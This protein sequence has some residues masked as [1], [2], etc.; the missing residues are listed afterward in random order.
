MKKVPVTIAILYMLLIQTITS[1]AQN[2]IADVVNV[3]EKENSS[4]EKSTKR[5][6]SVFH[7]GEIVIT[8]KRIAN[9]EKATTNTEITGDDIEMRSDKSLAD[10]LQVVPGVQVEQTAKGFTGLAMR[11]LNHQY[12]AILIDGVPVIDPYYGGNNIDISTIPVAHVERI[13]VNR[14]VSSALYG[15]LGSAGSINI[16]TKKPDQL[17]AKAKAEYGEYNNY[18]ISA[19]AGISIGNFYTCITA[20]RQRSEGY[21]I[22]KKLTKDKRREWFDKIVTYDLADQSGSVVHPAF[23]NIDLDAVYNYLHD[24]GKWNHTEYTK[25]TVGGKIGYLLNTNTEIGISANYYHNKQ[26]SNS[27]GNNSLP[28]FDEENGEWSLPVYPR[29]YTDASGRS[30][31]DIFS[32]RAF[33]WPEDYRLAVSPYFSMEYGDLKLRINTFYIKQ[34]NN[35]EGYFNQNHDIAQMYPNST[36]YNG[37][38]QSIF[39]ETAYGVYILPQ[40]ALSK[41]N[42]LYFSL[43]YRKE[44][45]NKYEKAL[46]DTSVLAGNLGTDEYQVQDIGADYVTIAVEDQWDINTGGGMLF[47]S[48]GIS[49]DAQKLSAL[50]TYDKTSDSLI[51]LPNM[52]NDSYIWGTND[53]F[54]P[55]A[56]AM[57]EAIPNLLTIRLAG[58]IKTMFPNLSQYKDIGED[59]T[60]THEYQLD[61][62]T[63][64]SSNAGFEITILDN[65]LSFRNDYFYTKVK[66]KIARIYDPESAYEKYENIDGVTAQ[67]IESTLTYKTTVAGITIGT[68]LNYVF[69]HARNDEITSLTYGER[70]EG[71]ATHQF[72]FQLQVCFPTMTELVMWGSYTADQIVYVADTSFDFT[73]HSFS[74]D[75]YNTVSLHNPTMLNIKLQQKFFTHYVVYISCKNI[76]DD[77]NADPFNP[78]P[79][80]MFYIG[81]NAEI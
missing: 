15:S 12:V 59:I 61:P 50:R 25:H 7:L 66:N 11:G 17:Y 44:Q 49:Y 71:I 69:T 45:H 2:D 6:Y 8:E 54:N 33:Y 72:L 37:D 39:E 28:Y 18:S 81:L 32:N 70:V 42:T 75:A 40:Y 34:R 13:I 31:R 63:I 26:Y 58:G 62:E 22:S 79:G 4:S 14:G 3:G 64:Y 57:Y 46:D 55:V 38:V 78:G 80:R 52:A 53:S 48:F 56:S 68:T 19:E 20:S 60:D 10:S 47:L 77:Y 74:A 23:D 30:W 41:N 35:L 29:D 76:L 21:E 73:S 27:F 65:A 16:I 67:G 9:I 43:H 36:N 51:Q 1:F 24:T 5:K